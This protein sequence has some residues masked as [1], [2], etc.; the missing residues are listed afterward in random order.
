MLCRFEIGAEWLLDDSACPAVLRLIQPRLANVKENVIEELRRRCE[1]EKPVRARSVLLHLVEAIF[2]RGVTVAIVE[3]A[4]VII[5]AL[6]K[7]LP[8]ILV[9]P[10]PGSFAIQ[11]LET[12]AKFLIRFFAASKTNDAQPRRQITIGS[13]IVECRNQLS[14]REIARRAKN[15][16][17][18]GFGMV[19]EA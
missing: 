17:N 9:M 15:D 18:T 13:E 5:N 6:G 16:E 19:A 12:F 3:I 14:V 4:F 8:E 10:L 1:V 7:L 11:F 2:E